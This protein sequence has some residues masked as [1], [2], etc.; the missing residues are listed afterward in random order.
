MIGSVIDRL[1]RVLRPSCVQCSEQTPCYCLP[2]GVCCECGGS[3]TL[4][5]FQRKEE[6][7]FAVNKVG[8]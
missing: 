6:C 4:D 3:S 5:M 2:A 7:Y 1:A 8:L